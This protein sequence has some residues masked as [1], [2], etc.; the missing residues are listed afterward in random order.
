MFLRIGPGV[1]GLLTI[2]L[3]TLKLTSVIAWSWW[4]IV[5]PLWLPIAVALV[6]IAGFVSVAIF[7]AWLDT[8]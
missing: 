7:L 3:T 4:W 5:S 8:R 1:I 2:L 6:A